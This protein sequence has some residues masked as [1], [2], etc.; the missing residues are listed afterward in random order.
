MRQGCRISIEQPARRYETIEDELVPVF[1]E[2]GIVNPSERI[3]IM[4]DKAHRTQT[5]DL[6]LQ[7]RG[8]GR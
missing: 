5:S 8:S 2:F 4:I 1:K 7:F 3:I 6:A